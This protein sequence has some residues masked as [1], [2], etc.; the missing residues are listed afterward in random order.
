MIKESRPLTHRR[1]SRFTPERQT[2]V[3]STALDVL[4]E[5]GYE[6]L[7][8]DAVA[9]RAHC[10]KATLYRQWHSK[11]DLI[12]V[13]LHALSPMPADGVDTGSLRSDL[14]TAARQLAQYAASDTRLFAAM[15]HALLTSDEL[16]RAVRTALQPRAE[17]MMSFVDRAVSRG[18]LPHRPVAAEFLPHI[19]WGLVMSH[20][21]LEGAFISAD[22]LVRFMD[23]FVLPALLNT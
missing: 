12:A 20:R 13:A 4:R 8:M 1:H 5:S 11:A 10:S 7:S 14:M 16:A 22:D 3:L 19:L 17:Q 21:A 2:E 6:A 9:A 15:G 23:S 18:E